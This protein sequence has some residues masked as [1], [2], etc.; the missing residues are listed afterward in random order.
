MGYDIGD[1]EDK[2]W[3]ACHIECSSGRVHFWNH[4]EMKLI[5][6]LSPVEAIRLA[7]AIEWGVPYYYGIEY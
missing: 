5:L 2:V 4:N 3:G 7:K 1:F 6:N